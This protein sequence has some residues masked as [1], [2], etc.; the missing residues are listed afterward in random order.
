MTLTQ[1]WSVIAIRK[2]TQIDLTSRVVGMQV[3][4]ELKLAAM[5]SGHATL[6]LNNNDGALTPGNGGTYTDT[7][8]FSYGLRIECTVSDG[9]NSK[10]GRLFDGIVADFK[11]Q[12]DG[13]N[14][15]VTLEADDFMTVAGRSPIPQTVVITFGVGITSLL[16]GVYGLAQF[17]DLGGTNPIPL[18]AGRNT[19]RIIF[20]GTR[21]QGQA[22]AQVAN[23]Q[24]MPMG[25]A[26]AW[27]TYMRFDGEPDAVFDPDFLCDVVDLPYNVTLDPVTFEF[28][29]TPTGTQLFAP[30]V[31]A[32]WNM[33]EV[34][35]YATLNR[36]FGTPQEGQSAASVAKYGVSAVAFTNLGYNADSQVAVDVPNWANRWDTPEYAAREVST[37]FKAIA[38]RCADA[39]YASWAD[40]LDMRQGLFQQANVSY[41]PTGAGSP[42]TDVCV[43]FGRTIQWTP[44]DTRVVLN[45]VPAANYRS[46]VLDSST[47]GVLDQN[48]LG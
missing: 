14:S 48:R 20:S 9:T 27:P 23:E 2:G 37:S 29:E 33:D 18:A 11:V 25:P 6:S 30:R 31:V 19:P 42:R 8:W 3:R 21:P 13:K 16:N 7:D 44:A 12:D 28:D 17:P 5:G 36:T 22:A 32:A 26:I 46:F 47:L 34:R 10:T 15:F 41:T 43:T 39:A 35:N 40:L 4:Q 24:A 1:T 45:V 38:A